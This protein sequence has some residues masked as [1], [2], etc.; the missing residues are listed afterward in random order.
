[1]TPKKLQKL[2]YYFEAWSYALLNQTLLNDTRFEAWV[3]GPVSPQ[4]YDKYR[5]YGWNNIQ[6]QADNSAIFEDKA[7]DLLQSVWVT[8]GE[9]SAN[10]LEALTHSET[11]WKNARYGLEETE[12]SHNEIADKDMHDY[13]LSIYIGD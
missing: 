4:L 10:E 8:Y 3:H 13:Y 9:K 11:P 6:Q 2:S 5:E 7:L 12:P 1:M